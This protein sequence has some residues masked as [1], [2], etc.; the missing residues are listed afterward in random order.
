VPTDTPSNSA[1]CLVVQNDFSTVDVAMS[2]PLAIASRLSLA[3][4]YYHFAASK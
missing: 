4:T 1:A 2:T 3:D